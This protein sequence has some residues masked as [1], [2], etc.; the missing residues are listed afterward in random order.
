MTDHPAIMSA[1]M[2]LACLREVCEPGTGKTETRRLAWRLRPNNKGISM[3]LGSLGTAPPLVSVEQGCPRD[4]APFGLHYWET[5]WQKR[6]AG[7]R[8]WVRE[9]FYT[10]GGAFGENFGYAADIPSDQQPPRLTPCIH[11]PRHLS[12]ITLIVTDVRIERLQDI[13]EEAARREGMIYRDHGLDRWGNV[14]P[15]WH[16][17]AATAERGPNHCLGG[18]KWAYGNLWQHLHGPE[19][20]AEN[21]WVV[22]VRFRPVLANID[23]KEVKA[24]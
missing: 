11:M 19:S 6:K 4:G 8:L 15:C 1:P 21:P 3:T 24:A 13:T 9:N 23:S 12:R 2:V 22:A 17:D 18:A 14:A 20:W 7:D 16:W 10:E 5:P